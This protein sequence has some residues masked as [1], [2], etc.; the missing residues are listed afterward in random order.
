MLAKAQ[1]HPVGKG[2]DWDVQLNGCTHAG[3][4]NCLKKVVKNI[5]FVKIV[6]QKNILHAFNGGP[7]DLPTYEA[8]L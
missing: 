4:K 2:W 6:N 3:R 8:R 7:T 1:S 5:N